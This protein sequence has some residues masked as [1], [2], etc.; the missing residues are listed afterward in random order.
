MYNLAVISV[1]AIKQKR[2]ARLIHLSVAFLFIGNAYGAFKSTANPDLIYIVAQIAI[3]IMIFT[4]VLTGDR[5]YANPLRSHNLFRTVEV[6]CLLYSAYY[7][8]NDLHNTVMSF[9]TFLCACGLIYLIF[10]EQKI[11][12]K[13][14][15]RL[16][17]KGIQ[18]PAGEGGKKIAWS[19][20][21]NLRIR[22]DYV[23]INTKQNRFIQYETDHNYDEA[24]L[25][26]MN[27]WCIR[28]LTSGSDLSKAE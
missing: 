17:E 23:S 28:H 26:E 1:A 14:F 24:L 6:F 9:L 19:H 4:K 18:L 12:K 15:V 13:Q 7:F 5:L 16:D 20:I 10:P 2:S 21:D 11:F 25:D 22:N 27:A 3:S 8:S